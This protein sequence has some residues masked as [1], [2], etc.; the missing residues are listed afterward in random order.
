MCEPLLK[1]S[2]YLQPEGYEQP[3]SGW[4]CEPTGFSRTSYVRGSWLGTHQR[5]PV[6]A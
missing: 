6:I 2:V 3:S 4:G 5:M 1:V